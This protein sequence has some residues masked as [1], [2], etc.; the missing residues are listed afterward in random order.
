M[1][2]SRRSVPDPVDDAERVQHVQPQL[3]EEEEVLVALGGA[4]GGAV[5]LGLTERRVAV[6]AHLR[7]PADA[8]PALAEEVGV[9]HL[10]S[11]AGNRAGRLQSE[12]IIRNEKQPGAITCCRPA[13]LGAAAIVAASDAAATP[14]GDAN[15]TS[16]PVQQL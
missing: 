12:A 1:S 2:V 9:G 6:T 16:S 11:R 15:S 7:W 14:S 8:A 4:C 5:H 3:R 10:P 13:C